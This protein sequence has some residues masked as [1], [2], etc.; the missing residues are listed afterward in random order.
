MPEIV[1]IVP[2]VLS[3]SKEL[4]DRMRELMAPMENGMPRCSNYNEYLRILGRPDNPENFVEWSRVAA[5]IIGE[6]Q[7]NA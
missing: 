6:P 5:T 7:G 3:P 1:T 4:E 2:S